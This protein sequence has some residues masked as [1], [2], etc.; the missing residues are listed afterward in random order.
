MGARAA[1]P[2]PVRDPGTPQPLF[3]QRIIEIG[4]EE[5]RAPRYGTPQL[6]DG[7]ARRA[8]GARIHSL[9]HRF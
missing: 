5:E 7:N 1:A 9:R 2:K 6:A 8:E 3:R 4:S